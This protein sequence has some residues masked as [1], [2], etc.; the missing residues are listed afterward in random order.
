MD[1]RYIVYYNGNEPYFKT[2]G[3]VV[4]DTVTGKIYP[5]GVLPAELYQLQEKELYQQVRV[6]WNSRFP[7]QEEMDNRAWP[8][9]S[10][11]D[12][13]FFTTQ[14]IL[15]LTMRNITD[16]A[17]EKSDED[18]RRRREWEAIQNAM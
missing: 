2:K 6:C 17:Q 5:D 15:V 3:F 4:K 18:A 10:W 8:A 12:N 9:I 16:K 1:Y 14:W 7:T 11:F 13:G